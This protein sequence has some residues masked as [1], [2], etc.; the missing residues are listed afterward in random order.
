MFRLSILIDKVTEMIR[1]DSIE[2]ITQRFDVYNAITA[3]LEK[4]VRHET[5]V[6]LLLEK[7]RISN[8]HPG[9]KAL[10]SRN[11]VYRFQDTSR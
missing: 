4:I 6:Q 1:N 8:D 3:F 9:I 7:R 5:L 2:D 11:S 10:G